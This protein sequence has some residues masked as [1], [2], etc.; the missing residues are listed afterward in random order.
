LF[1]VTVEGGFSASHALLM[2]GG[3]RERR[4]NHE[5]R[6]RAGF[7]A[8]KLDEQGLA[9]DFL[10]IKRAIEEITGPLGGRELESMAC[11]AGKN[12]SAERVAVYI[13]E[14]IAGRFAGRANLEYVEVME[15]EG[16]WVKYDG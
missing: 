4:H 7:S 13:Y 1:I 11:F 10:D 5:W 3:V 16:C 12:A 9:V 14:Q 2:C 15:A 6:V 8:E